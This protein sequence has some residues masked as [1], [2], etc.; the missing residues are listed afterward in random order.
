MDDTTAAPARAA[1]P[2]PHPPAPAGRRGRGRALA[3][4]GIVLAAAAA[5]VALVSVVDPHEPGHYPTCPLLWATGLYCPGCGGLR[6]VNSLTHGRVGEAFGLNPMAFLLLPVFAYLWARWTACAAKGVPFASA[7]VRPRV[8][9]P[10][11]ALII[12][13]WIVRNLPFGHALAP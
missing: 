1:H 10:F 11:L 13:Y 5:G 6:M 7:L 9:Y 4:P 2:H 12:V 8:I 3:G